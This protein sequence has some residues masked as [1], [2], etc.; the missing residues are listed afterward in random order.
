MTATVRVLL[1]VFFSSVVC[2]AQNFEGK[3]TYQNSFKS[4]I[5]NVTD[6]MFT[7]MMG[8]SWDYAIK[9]AKYH[10]AANGTLLQWQLYVPQ[11]NKL[12]TKMSNSTSILWNDAAV[13]PDEVIKA[14]VNKNA[15]TI[16]GHSCDEVVLTCK[17]G[18]QKY[19][20]SPKYKLDAKLFENHK[21]GNF[22]EFLSHAKA[23]PL[24]IIIDNVQFSMESVATAIQAQKV[25]DQR[26][27]LPANV[28]L[29]KSPF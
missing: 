15:A 10:T 2:I 20:F 27:V 22:Y 18:V 7:E 29:E 28:P 26:F 21:Y 12:Y 6:E 4:K 3:I 16:L 13:N 25:D 1:L 8:S 9:G 14:E 23:I 5:P 11:D 19:Y 24:K 17:S